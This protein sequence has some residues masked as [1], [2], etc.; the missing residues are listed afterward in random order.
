MAYHFLLQEAFEGLDLEAD[1]DYDVEQT[2]SAYKK[3]G[4]VVKGEIF[5]Y[6]FI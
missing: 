1:E 3:K 6:R 4:G 2:I 5:L